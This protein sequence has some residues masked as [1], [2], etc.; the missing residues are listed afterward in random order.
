MEEGGVFK[1]MQLERACKLLVIGAI[2]LTGCEHQQSEQEAQALVVGEWS[3]TIGRDCSNYDVASDKLVLHPNGTLEQHTVSKRGFRYDAPAERWK[4]SSE[5]HVVLDSRKDFFNS[6]PQ[7]EF[8][9]VR[10]FEVLLVKFTSPPT[11]LLNPKSDCF[12]TKTK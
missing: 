10:R 3:L 2:V 11:I 1:H 4:Y 6:Q 9:G 8:A 5:N 7:N 12:Y